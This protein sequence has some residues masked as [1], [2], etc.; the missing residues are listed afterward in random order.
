MLFRSS[1]DRVTS[2][3]NSLV[4]SGIPTTTSSAVA[5]SSSYAQLFTTGASYSVSMSTLRSNTT[6]QNLLYNPDVTSRISIGFNQPLL[7]GFGRM[8][9]ARFMTV[10]RNN[11]GTADEVF[12]Q[13]VMNSIAQL[14]DAY[15]NLR[16]FQENVQVTQ[17]SLAAVQKLFNDTQRQE[18]AGVASHLD[19][20]TA[21]SEVASSQRD[22]LVAQTN[23]EQQETSLKQLLSKRN[24]PDLDAATI[25]VT[26]P[27]PEPR[28]S[29]LPQLEK[30]LSVALVNRPEIKEAA[31]NLLNQGIAIQYA[32][33]NMQPSLAVFGLYAGSG[34]KGDTKTQSAGAFGAL[35]QTFDAA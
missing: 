15:Y 13:Q 35:G 17:E 30:A 5:F 1:Y 7:A 6:Q 14:E 2:P 19:V 23:L 28:E 21:E 29:D 24:D 3:L 11:I 22:L 34:L 31:N 33:N 32:K 20:I 8:A 27:L 18:A 10:A 25:V 9:N 16:A 4:V 12:R 26:D